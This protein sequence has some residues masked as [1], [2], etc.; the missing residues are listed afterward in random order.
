MTWAV[1]TKFLNPTLMLRL[2]S[3]LHHRAIF[4]ISSRARTDGNCN[5]R[6]P[7]FC[8]SIKPIQLRVG[9]RG[10]RYSSGGG[11]SEN[12]SRFFRSF[13]NGRG[14]FTVFASR[15]FYEPGADT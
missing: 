10:P 7:F 12:V 1:K 5:C 6:F 13:S 15:D 3:A 4:A 9:A 11:E 8:C 2:C 14:I